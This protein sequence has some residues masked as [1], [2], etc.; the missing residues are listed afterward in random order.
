MQPCTCLRTCAH[1]FS[2]VAFGST[3]VNENPFTW[4]VRLIWL[5][6]H[7]VIAEII[8]LNSAQLTDEQIY[9]DARKLTLATMQHVIMD[10]WLP[11]L[12]GQSLPPYSGYQMEE[13]SEEHTSELQSRFDLVCR[14][15]LEKK[16]RRRH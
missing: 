4:S 9:Q 5:R 6:F 15:L 12:L 2:F 13:R 7:N 10:E 11:V 8:S 1:H 3:L 14:L 16:N